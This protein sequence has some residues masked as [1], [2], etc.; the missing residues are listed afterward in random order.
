[1]GV[2]AIF[3]DL[4]PCC[5]T[6]ISLLFEQQSPGD[7][8][9]ENNCYM[10]SSTVFIFFPLVYDQLGLIRRGKFLLDNGSIGFP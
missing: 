7:R 5:L 4:E 2:S 3:T 6:Q 10:A 9:F 1:M 8:G